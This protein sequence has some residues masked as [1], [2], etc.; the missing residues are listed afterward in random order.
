MEDLI[1]MNREDDVDALQAGHTR[2]TE[3]RIYG[4]SPQ[5]L[6][7]AA[8]DILP[9]FLEASTKWQK[10]CKAMPGGS[11]LPYRQARSHLVKADPLER[12]ANPL[13]NQS[14]DCAIDASMVD[15]IA[16]H[17]V[18]CLTLML[19]EMMQA[20]TASRSPPLTRLDRG[21][22]RQ[23]DPLE[24]ERPS[25]SGMEDIE[26]AEFQAAILTSI[27]DTRNDGS[28]GESSATGRRSAPAIQQGERPRCHTRIDIHLSNRCSRGRHKA[29]TSWASD[30]AR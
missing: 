13:R 21:K 24:D 12:R 27:K 9:L 5:S 10:C 4:L 11:G 7:G 30:R 28:M 23:I 1:E 29:S 3:N 20:I 15:D 6:A 2:A 19:T 26:E 14:T 22:Q 18:E 8:E 17:V 25:F 16:T